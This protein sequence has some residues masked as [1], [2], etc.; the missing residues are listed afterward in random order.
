MTWTWPEQPA[1]APMPMVGMCSRS[2]MAAREL[3]GHQLEHDR[4]GARLLD[5]QRVGEQRARRLAVLALDPDLAAH[6]VLG[7]RR[8]ADV[9]HDRDPARTS[10]SM[11]RALRTPPSTLTA[12][13]PASRM[14]RPAF[15][16]ASSG[17]GVG[18]ERH[19]AHDQGAA[20]SRAT[21]A[22]VWWSIS[23]IVTR[24]VDS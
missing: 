22:L 2:V 18:Q 7:L 11:V 19:V 9:A 24:T 5:G 12:W 15:S 6:A 20:A 13:A 4:E 21:T 17:V 14:N 3:L 16:T 1:P 10:A 23:S 8:P